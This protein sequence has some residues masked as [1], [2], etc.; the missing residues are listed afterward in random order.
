MSRGAQVLADLQA[1]PWAYPALE[2]IHLVGIALLLGNLLVF[3]LRLAGLGAP[4]PISPLAR[5]ALPSAIA[6][7]SLAL[8]SGLLMFATQPVDLLANPAFRLKMLLILL[9]GLNAV[10]F[11]LRDSIGRAAGGQ[12]DPTG[13]L[14]GLVSLLLWIG[15]L[16][17]GR[18]IA[19]V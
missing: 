1:H 19:Y 12:T 16:A 3:E 10:W 15:V 13:R 7:F 18:A 6:G 2:V 8:P 14:L 17:C 4:I 5:L 9:A 11:H